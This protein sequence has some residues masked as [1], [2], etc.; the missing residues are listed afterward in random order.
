MRAARLALPLLGMLSLGACAEMDQQQRAIG[1]G[2]LGGA[3][4]G[5]IAGSFSGDSGWG[6]LIGAGVG[7]GAGYLYDQSQQHQN[8]NNRSNRNYR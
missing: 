1:T 3:A 7:A 8:R 2:A 4:L 5:G 6:A